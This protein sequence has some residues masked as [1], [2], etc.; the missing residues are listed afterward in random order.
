MLNNLRNRLCKKE[1][2]LQS[3]Y[4]GGLPAATPLTFAS[5]AGFLASN[6]SPSTPTCNRWRLV[7]KVPDKFVPR[8]GC[9]RGLGAGG[10]PGACRAAGEEDLEKINDFC[11]GADIIFLLV[12]PGGAARRHRR[13]PGLARGTGK[14]ARWC[15][16]P[17]T[18]PLTSRVIAAN[19]KL[20]PDCRQ[21]AIHADAVI[22]LP[23][24]KLLQIAG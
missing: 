19:S 15:W 17:V 16:P 4:L 2:R 6:S 11:A 7:A 8:R 12:G 23:N 21:L 22:C 10:D 24:R 1:A 14:K 5:L 20:R 13:E 9:T 3:L 18:L